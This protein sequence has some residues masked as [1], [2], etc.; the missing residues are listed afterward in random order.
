VFVPGNHEFDFG[1]EIYAERRAQAKFPFLAANL[2]GP[3]GKPLPGH[4]DRTI[5]DA[6]GIRVGIVGLAL[7]ATPNLSNP[8]DL[9]FAPVVETLKEQAKALRNE[10]ADLVVA[11]THTDFSTDM[12]IVSQR[13]A[14]VLLT[15]HDHDLRLYYDGRTVMAESGEDAHYVVVIELDVAVATE[16]GRRRARW[17]PRFRIVNTADVTPDPA[18]AA[19]VKGYESELSKEL[20]VPLAPTMVELD[21]RNVA[22]RQQEN[23][24]GNLVADAVRVSTEADVAIIN[25]GGF[26]GN[27]VYPEGATLTRRDVISEMPFGNTTVMIEI[28]GADIRAALENGFSE[29]ERPSGRFPQI[30]GM[31]VVVDRSKPKGARVVSAKVQGQPLD[32]AKTYRLATNNYMLRGGDGYGVF[33]GQMRLIGETDGKLV[34]GEAMAYMRRLGTIETKPEGRIVIR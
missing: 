31:S 19:K 11:V 25:G 29:I 13:L 28:S 8:G 10:G 16:D 3:D 18:V 4:Q 1:K 22:M 12:Q 23:G 14:D 2:R 33:T 7:E 34:A 24:F 17:T 5:V 21:T 30:S 20:D 32:D 15:G 26:R 27:R 6:N 9:R